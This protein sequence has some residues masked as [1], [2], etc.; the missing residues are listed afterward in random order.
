M[1]IILI[2]NV[3]NEVD[4]MVNRSIKTL[5]VMVTCTAGLAFGHD[6]DQIS[7]QPGALAMFA[8]LMLSVL[9]STAA[10]SYQQ[11]RDRKATPAPSAT[12]EDLSETS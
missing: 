9:I 12:N 6:H 5:L 7:D 11:S 8:L 4:E 2:T 3:Q 1:I 10:I